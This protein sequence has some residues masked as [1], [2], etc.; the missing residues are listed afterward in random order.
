[1][2]CNYL[3]CMIHLQLLCCLSSDGLLW[4]ST[5]LVLQS[6]YPLTSTWWLVS[7]PF[8]GRDLAAYVCLLF[9]ARTNHL[10]H[11]ALWSQ[12]AC[13]TIALVEWEVLVFIQSLI[14]SKPL[15]PAKCGLILFCHSINMWIYY[16]YKEDNTDQYCSLSCVLLCEIVMSSKFSFFVTKDWVIKLLLLL[17]LGFWGKPAVY[18]GWLWCLLSAESILSI[19][20]YMN[21]FPLLCFSCI[22]QELPH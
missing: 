7:P 5:W 21:S 14:T 17:K 13:R 9:R 11:K 10:K 12:L 6:F 19:L 8:L 2:Y 15:S 22:Q 16:K 1:M 4:G 3:S 18:L 20:S